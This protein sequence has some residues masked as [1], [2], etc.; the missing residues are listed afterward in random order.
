MGWLMDTD[1]TVTFRVQ[2]PQTAYYH[3]CV[4]YCYTLEDTRNLPYSLLIDGAIPFDEAENLQLKRIWSDEGSM[5]QD[6]QGNDLIPQQQCLQQW[7]TVQAAD[8][9]A[10][11]AEAENKSLT[12]AVK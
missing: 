5:T 11:V 12:K 10:A 8:Y 9:A 7:Q 4:R 1:S 3:L 6:K 2:V